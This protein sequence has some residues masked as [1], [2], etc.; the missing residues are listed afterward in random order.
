[1]DVRRDR[2]LAPEEFLI[3]GRLYRS[4]CTDLSLSGAWRLPRHV[5]LYLEDLVS[6]SH[7]HLYAFHNRR[8]LSEIK[9]FFL[10]LIPRSVFNDRYVRICLLAFYLPFFTSMYLGFQ[11]RPF[12]VSLV[13]ETQMEQ[14]EEMH[15]RERENPEAGDMIAGTGFYVWNNAGLAILT[16]G[17][18]ILGGVLSLVM[19]L[20]NA[21]YLGAIM[22]FLMTTPAAENILSWIPGHGPFELTAIAFAGAAG[23]RVGFSFVASDGR[24]RLRALRE[25][26][27]AAVPVLVASVVMLFIAA[28]LE[29]TLAPAAFPIPVKFAV[30]GAT[31]LLLIAY[32]GFYGAI[33]QRRFVRIKAARAQAERRGGLRSYDAASTGSTANSGTGGGQASGRS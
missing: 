3:F 21:A 14:F 32:F 18:G 19:V 1:M 17:V 4:A 25:E 15:T 10:D 7:S 29:A 27:A 16:F 31:L 30:G 2:K 13:G 22:G 12:V 26:S 24:R 33:C 5:Q 23:L 20:F 28:F 11:S 9:A 8:R 6:R